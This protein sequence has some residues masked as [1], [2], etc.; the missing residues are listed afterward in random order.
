[1]SISIVND[2]KDGI[3]GRFT[4]SLAD[5]SQL[6]FQTDIEKN[7][8]KQTEKGFSIIPLNID[9]VDGLLGSI[10]LDQSYEITLTDNYI[11]GS[12]SQTNDELKIQKLADLQGKVIS[13]YQDLRINKNLVDSRILIINNLSVNEAEYLDKEKTIVMSFTFNVKY[14]INN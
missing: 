11:N 8:T 10:T 9:E 2:I 14:K 3:K 13:A 12:K 5:Y 4:T 1:M 6:P 7:K